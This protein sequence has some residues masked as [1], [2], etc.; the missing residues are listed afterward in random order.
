MKSRD[1][2]GALGWSE[3]VGRAEHAEQFCDYCVAVVGCDSEENY[4]LMQHVRSQ[5]GHEH[6]NVEEDCYER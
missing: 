1:A 4:F 3:R 5:A 2:L 6:D